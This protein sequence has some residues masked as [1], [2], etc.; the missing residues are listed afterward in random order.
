MA[1]KTKKATTVADQIRKMIS[2]NVI[3]AD[4]K[5]AEEYLLDIGYYRLGFYLYPFETTYPELG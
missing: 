1:N 3:I 2:R 4:T 5:K